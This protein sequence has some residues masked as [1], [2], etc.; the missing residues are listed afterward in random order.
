[1]ATVLT[2]TYD[3]TANSN[4][5]T[6]T[7]A[8]LATSAG[9]VV[10]R[11]S[12]IID[13]AS[14]KY[15]DVILSGQV[16]VGTTPTAGTIAVYVFAPLKVVSSAYTYPIATTTALGGTDAAATFE[17]G[18]LGQLRFAGA[19]STVAT[20]DRAYAFEPVSIAS[21]FGG[22]MPLACGVFVTHSTGVN[23]NATAG[24]HWFH[25]TGITATST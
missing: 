17:A 11:Q 22:V 10:G 16:T 25:W 2:T 12:T 23:L 21:L 14:T 20:S 18:Q 13:N 4:A 9:L 5:V 19:A 15:L 8:S 24:N 6:I 3:S 1:M 7:L